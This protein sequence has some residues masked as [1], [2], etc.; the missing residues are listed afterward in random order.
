MECSVQPEPNKVESLGSNQENKPVT[1]IPSFNETKPEPIL[2][3]GSAAKRE[4]SG[5]QKQTTHQSETL[6]LG[7][8]GKR[9]QH[10]RQL[11][12]NSAARAAELE[13]WFAAWFDGLW[14]NKIAREEAWRVF[15]KLSPDRELMTQI[16][17]KTTEWANSWDWTKQGGEFAPR[18]DKWL[19]GKRWNDPAPR[20]D[21]VDVA[22]GGFSYVEEGV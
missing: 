4:H 10:G 11:Q 16:A 2:N 21:P 17:L 1:P 18:A 9:E 22:G 14:P 3:L 13:S 19:R 15:N 8:A 7:S 6:N 12:K 5:W 20:P